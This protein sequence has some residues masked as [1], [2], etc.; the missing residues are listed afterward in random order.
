VLPRPLPAGIFEH[1]QPDRRGE[2]GLIAV[3]VDVTDDVSQGHV[4]AMGNV[5]QAAPE[6]AFQTDGTLRCWQ[7]AIEQWNSAARRQSRGNSFQAF[8]DERKR[9]FQRE[10][11]SA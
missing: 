2:V 8:A 3:A 10:V 6:G 5:L 1:E 11:R 7:G 4:P 9:V